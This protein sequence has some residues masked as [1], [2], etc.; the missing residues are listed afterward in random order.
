MKATFV[1]FSKITTRMSKVIFDSLINPNVP[2][3]PWYIRKE[4]FN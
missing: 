3:T 4:N 1:P 2:F